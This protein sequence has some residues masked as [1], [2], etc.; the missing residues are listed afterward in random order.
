MPQNLEAEQA[1]L[2]SMLIDRDA[3]A[4]VSELLLP[5]DFYR[6]AHRLLYQVALHLFD[7]SQEIDL[8]TVTEEL[9]RREQ[10][11]AVGGPAYL[12]TL[13]DAVPAASNVARYAEI[14]QEKSLLRN[15]ILASDQIAGW[16]YEAAEPVD[17]I[18]DK[19]EQQI[20][21]V[22]QRQSTQDFTPIKPLLAE[23]FERIDKQYKE[24]GEA[25]GIPTDFA[26]LDDLT[27]GL[28]KSE[29]VIVAARPSM[30][31]TAFV[32]NIARNVAVKARE[33]VGIFS[34]E[35]SKEALVQ[36]LICSEAQINAMDLRRGYLQED[37]WLK[38]GAAIETLYDTPLFIDDTP[39]IS[40]FEIRAKAR[41]LKAEHGIG[42]I[43]VDYLQLV[44]T[45]GRAENRQVEVSM[46][47]QSLKSLARELNIPV[48]ACSQL[49]R[50]LESRPKDEKRPMLSDL[51]ESG[52]IEQDA[53]VVMFIYRE[54]RYRRDDDED[55]ASGAPRGDELDP[56]EIIVAKQRN[57]PTGTV[58]LGFFGPHTR[59]MSLQPEDLAAPPY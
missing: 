57:G 54:S 22:A 8:V 29:L 15:L 50:A 39:A 9:R 35:M 4:R 59:F 25:V 12:T 34:L 31:K 28:N 21:G 55:S 1:T 46:I 43:I 20:F 16:A 56:T 3:V 52:A 2:G 18:V 33:G 48:I 36:R 19:A 38:I 32:L 47:A 30:G 51:R 45:T 7:K 40:T 6:E 10:L 17:E 26:D 23:A 49:S 53:D 24:R 42:L 5:E 44:R 37:D 41:R 14:V 11:D 58:K 27:S 13:I